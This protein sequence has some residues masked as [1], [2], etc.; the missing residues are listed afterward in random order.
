MSKML[1]VFIILLLVIIVFPLVML[2][3]H[4]ENGYIPSVAVSIIKDGG[5]SFTSNPLFLP[6][7][8]KL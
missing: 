6:S 5:K 2:Y 8:G 4:K 7:E 1:V 3:S